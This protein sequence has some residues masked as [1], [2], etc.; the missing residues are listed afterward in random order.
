MTAYKPSGFSRIIHDADR[1]ELGHAHSL[2]MAFEP[3]VSW[4]PAPFTCDP[5][6]LTWQ[7]PFFF[8][9]RIYHHSQ[10]YMT[11]ISPLGYMSGTCTNERDGLDQRR[12]PFR[13]LGH[14]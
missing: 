13:A 11:W 3:F 8:P 12:S 10:R 6:C 4:Q 5:A 14:P 9:L 1:P 2:N 7:R